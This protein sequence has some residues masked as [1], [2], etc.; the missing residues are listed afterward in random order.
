MNNNDMSK[1][2]RSTAHL[3]TCSEPTAQAASSQT[4]SIY[5]G[6][7]L[8][9]CWANQ[10]KLLF[11]SELSLVFDLASFSPPERQH[12]NP[13]WH[14]YAVFQEL[15]TL[16]NQYQFPVSTHWVATNG[17]ISALGE[18]HS[19]SDSA[20]SQRIACESCLNQRST[21]TAPLSACTEK[22][23]LQVTRAPKHTV[24][25]WCVTGWLL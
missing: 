21:Q 3:R 5:F 22:W 16:N 19:P 13:I 17:S 4:S 23:H 18:F 7:S 15:Q 10:G 8:N 14:G 11:I 6:I 9:F 2:S 12:T 1:H 20:N 24:I 25:F